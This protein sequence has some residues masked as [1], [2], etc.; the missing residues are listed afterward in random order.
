MDKNPETAQ[1][2]KSFWN[3]QEIV[4]LVFT[5]LLVVLPI[6]M[7]LA[8]PFLVDGASMYPTFKNSEY[9]IVDELS[10]LF[11]TPERGSVIVF[12]YPKD[13]SRDFIKRVIGLPGE[14]LKI[15]DGVV[16]IINAENPQGLKLDEPYIKL[17][18]EETLAYTLG[19][20]EYYVM[21]DNRAQSADSRFWGPLPKSYIIGR[22]IL[23]AYP[24]GVWPGDY[25]NLFNN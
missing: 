17:P 10:Y 14:T 7:I 15:K 12:H 13:P 16:T 6:R 25:T 2:T 11:K 23:R 5:V 18:K 1:P 24:F 9:L 3:F 21:G 4:N 22:P 20:D 8:Q 19:E